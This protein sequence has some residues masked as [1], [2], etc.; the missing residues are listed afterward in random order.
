MESSEVVEG[1]FMKSSTKQDFNQLYSSVAESIK[2]ALLD[3]NSLDIKHKDGQQELSSIRET[4]SEIQSSFNEELQL[5]EQHAEWEKF[6]IAFFGET[7]A[8]K[9][10]IIESLRIL[11]EESSRQ[12]L[13][14]KNAHDLVKYEKE[15]LDNVNVVR[16]ALYETYSEYTKQ[17]NE[18]KERITIVAQI[19]GEESTTR[20]K[21]RQWIY[22]VAGVFLGSSATAILLTF[23]HG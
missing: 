1:V 14:S 2:S 18:M 15:L 8:G 9:S 21:T 19:V 17:F 13:L 11:F 5:L 22:A 10:T 3:I 7:N 12:E 6:T 23:L 20:M 16:E 4:L